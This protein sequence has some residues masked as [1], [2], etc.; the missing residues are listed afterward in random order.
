[1]GN[2]F[3]MRSFFWHLWTGQIAG[4]RKVLGD[5]WHKRLT[6][7]RHINFF[8]MTF[9]GPVDHLSFSAVISTL[10]QARTFLDDPDRSA[11]QTLIVPGRLHE[12]F[13]RLVTYIRPEN[14][15]RNGQGI[16]TVFTFTLQKRKKR[17]NIFPE[18]LICKFKTIGKLTNDCQPVRLPE[19]IESISA[20]NIIS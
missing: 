6:Q 2:Q 13:R 16:R 18:K 15:T 19:F 5:A 3:L 1:M 10:S 7:Y 9:I 17:C 11:L 12:R 14:L 4:P 8:I 20:S